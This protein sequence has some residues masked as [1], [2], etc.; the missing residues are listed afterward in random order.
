MTSPFTLGSPFTL[1]YT[2]VN[3]MHPKTLATHMKNDSFKSIIKKKLYR[4]SEIYKMA[5]SRNQ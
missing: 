2:N 5:N 4:F 1:K 3:Q